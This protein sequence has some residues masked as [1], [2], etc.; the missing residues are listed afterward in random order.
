M[1]AISQ[2][3]TTWARVATTFFHFHMANSFD[4]NVYVTIINVGVVVVLAVVDGVAVTIIYVDVYCR[5]CCH[6]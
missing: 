1:S 6:C 2:S 5:C 4:A 3:T